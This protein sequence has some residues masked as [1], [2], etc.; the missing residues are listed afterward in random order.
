MYVLYMGV[1]YYFELFNMF[2]MAHLDVLNVDRRVV[3]GDVTVTPLRGGKKSRSLLEH[4][5]LF[6]REPLNVRHPCI[7]LN[8]THGII[9]QTYMHTI[10][11]EMRTRCIYLR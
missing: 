11:H 6:D 4:S 9:V 2:I 5:L 10:F 3:R 8:D 1:I 7:A